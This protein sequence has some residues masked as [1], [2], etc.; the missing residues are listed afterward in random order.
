MTVETLAKSLGFEALCMP[1]G[2]REVSG[3]YIGDLLS[4]VMGRAGQDNVWIT[5][6]SNINIVAVATLSDVACILLAENVTLDDEVRSV[7]EQR[8][9]NVIRTPLSAYDAAILISKALC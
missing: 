1:D 8:K 2:D 9:V 7:A 6:I 3:A 5:I 4:W